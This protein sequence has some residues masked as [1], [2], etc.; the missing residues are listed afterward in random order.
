MISVK[1]LKVE[2]LI[3]TNKINHKCL[4]TFYF[5]L[6]KNMKLNEYVYVVGKDIKNKTFIIHMGSTVKILKKFR[7]LASTNDLL[8][9]M[10]DIQNICVQYYLTEVTYN[11][12]GE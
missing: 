11:H 4:K 2:F 5:N 3:H 1:S 10:Y 12:T 7:I 6:I 9:D 8:C